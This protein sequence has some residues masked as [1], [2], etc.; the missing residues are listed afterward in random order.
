MHFEIFNNIPAIAFEIGL[1]VEEL[2]LTSPH[3]KELSL[4]FG[5]VQ[6]AY[7]H[8]SNGLTAAADPRR[9][10]GIALGGH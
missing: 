6:A 7:S 9:T 5:G 2:N 4:Y 1:N 10:G 8:P 3:F